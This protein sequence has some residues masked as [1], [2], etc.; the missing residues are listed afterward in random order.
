VTRRDVG[1]EPQSL[2]FVSNKPGLDPKSLHSAYLFR[3]YNISRN[4]AYVIDLWEVTSKEG[5]WFLH[6]LQWKI[7]EL[8]P[9]I[10]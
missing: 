2:E 6:R 7:L 3:T 5:K 1:P 8:L 4:I 10:F 9:S